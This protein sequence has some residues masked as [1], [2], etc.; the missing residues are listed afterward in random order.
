[1]RPIRSTWPRHDEDEIEAA[2]AVLR[3]GRVNARVH[4]EQCTAFENEF[5]AYCG[6]PYGIA[7]ANGTLALDLALRALGIGEGDEV[8]VPA[9]SFFATASC[10]PG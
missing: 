9:R 2:A 7:A 4:G 3:S 1:M 10:A 6:M 8:I 5:A